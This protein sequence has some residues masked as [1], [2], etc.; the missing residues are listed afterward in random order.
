MDFEV[1]ASTSVSAPPDVVFR[2]ITD[3]ARLPQWNKEISEIREAPA[4]VEP[5]AQWLVEIKA[6]GTHWGSRSEAIE[7]DAATRVFAYRSVTDD[8]NPSYADWRWELTAH[9]NGNATRVDV[10]MSAH[11]RT[12]WRKHL[13]SNLRRPVLRRA[14]QRSLDAL[15]TSV[16]NPVLTKEAP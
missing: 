9:D 1:H 8:G 10:V 5:G 4:V 11:P 14:M 15:E 12:F 2:H 3:I 7:V 13:L 6:M 16:H